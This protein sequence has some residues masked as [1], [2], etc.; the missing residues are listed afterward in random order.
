[1][2][3][4]LIYTDIDSFKNFRP[5]TS[6][7]NGDFVA[8]IKHCTFINAAKEWNLEEYAKIYCKYVDYKILEGYNPD[9]KLILD[10]RHD[11]GKSRCV[12]RYVMKEDNK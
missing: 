6:T 11:T 5:V 9:V 3:N 8:K 4:W 1:L 10:S 12:F 2:K 7:P